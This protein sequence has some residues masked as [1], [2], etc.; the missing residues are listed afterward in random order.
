MHRI[1]P[2]ASQRRGKIWRT[3]KK[4]CVNPLNAT[5]AAKPFRNAFACD[6]STTRFWP[7]RDSSTRYFR[8]RSGAGFK[9][10]WICLCGPARFS[11][12]IGERPD[13]HY[14]SQPRRDSAQN[15]SKHVEAGGRQL[16]GIHGRALALTKSRRNDPCP[17]GSGKKYKNCCGK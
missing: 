14:R 4:I 17:C 8:Q 11:H 12:P 7:R 1:K 6:F 3:W 13:S 5:L 15:T 2:A 16:G 9:T 10:T